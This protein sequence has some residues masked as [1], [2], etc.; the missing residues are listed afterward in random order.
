MAVINDRLDQHSDPANIGL[1]SGG[2]CWVVDPKDP[3][4]LVPIGAPGELLI[5]GPHVGCG[6]LHD[7]ARTAAAFIRQPPWL[8]AL[9]RGRATRV[10]KTGDLVRYDA[11]GS[12]LFLGRIDSGQVA[13]TAA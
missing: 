1:A 12:L 5:E 4:R 11:D 6:Y 7:P 10:Y 2:V 8:Q 3:R 9:R 13:R